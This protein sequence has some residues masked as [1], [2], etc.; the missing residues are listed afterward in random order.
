MN[1]AIR[2]MLLLVLDVGDDVFDLIDDGPAKMA[3]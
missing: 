1:R 2:M 3:R